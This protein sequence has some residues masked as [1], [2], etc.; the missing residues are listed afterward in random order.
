MGHGRFLLPDGEELLSGLNRS[1][2]RRFRKLNQ[3]LARLIDE[4]SLVKF[5]PLNIY[6]EDSMDSLLLQVDT[7]TQFGEDAEVHDRLVGEDESSS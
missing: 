7:A 4:F 3:A 5:V 2:S 1:V 6:S